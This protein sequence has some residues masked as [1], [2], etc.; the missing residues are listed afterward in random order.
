MRDYQVIS[1]SLEGILSH[2]Y[3]S[4]DNIKRPIEILRIMDGPASKG[5]DPVCTEDQMKILSQYFQDL[6]SV[7]I[8]KLSDFSIESAFLDQEGVRLQALLQ[9]MI[10]VKKML[11][12]KM[13]N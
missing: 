4:Y 11:T 10:K 3:L 8:K 2:E 1:P 6:Y 9:E 13:E 5:S 12:E 7:F